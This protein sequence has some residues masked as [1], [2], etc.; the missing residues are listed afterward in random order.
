L[1]FLILKRCFWWFW[2]FAL[3]WFN[4]FTIPELF[5][6]FIFPGNRT[7]VSSDWHRLRPLG[8][9]A[10]SCK[11]KVW[12]V[13]AEGNER[14]YQP[15]CQTTLMFLSMQWTQVPFILHAL[16]LIAW[17]QKTSIIKF[18]SRRRVGTSSVNNKL[19]GFVKILFLFV[20]KAT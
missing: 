15:S 13:L 5:R 6:K 16:Q 1:L 7:R 10:T 8:Y 11:L 18:L 12:R 20:T 4:L 9:S 3:L 2:A 17:V 19:G 14:S